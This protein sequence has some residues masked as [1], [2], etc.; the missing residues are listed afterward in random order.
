MD[1]CQ[2]ALASPAVTSGWIT[3]P[4]R[5][6]T[7][8]TWKSVATSPVSLEP[9]FAAIRTDGSL[10]TWGDNSFGQLGDGTLT[11]RTAPVRITTATNWKTVV[12]GGSQPS[13]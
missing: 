8:A 7:V 1:Q 13:R 4:R 11:T 9:D 12:V 2:G 5:L 3:A 6:G 10:W